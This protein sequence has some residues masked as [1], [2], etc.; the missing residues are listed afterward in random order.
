MLQNAV[1]LM[2]LH[3]HCTLSNNYLL[4]CIFCC[5]GLHHKKKDCNIEATVQKFQT[6]IDK[7]TNSFFPP[8][9]FIQPGETSLISKFGPNGG[10]GDSRDHALCFQLMQNT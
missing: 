4:F 5:S 1:F 3:V 9:V 7:N 10:W 2:L 8:S 6:V